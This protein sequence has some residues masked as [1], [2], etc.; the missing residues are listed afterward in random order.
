MD[1][2]YGPYYDGQF[3]IGFNAL[4]AITRLQ[5]LSFYVSLYEYSSL[6]WGRANIVTIFAFV[7]VD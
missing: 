5:F 3:I 6:L 1:Y 4:S 2:I 7:K